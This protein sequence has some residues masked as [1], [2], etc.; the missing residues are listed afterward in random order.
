MR[1][2]SGLLHTCPEGWLSQCSQ[3]RKGS[4]WSGWDDHKEASGVDLLPLSPWRTRSVWVSQDTAA[5][6]GSSEGADT[7]RGEWCVAP[8]A[9]PLSPA[10]PSHPALPPV[11]RPGP[12]RMTAGFHALPCAVEVIPVP[13]AATVEKALASPGLGVVE[14]PYLLAL[15]GTY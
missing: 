6:P 2:G 7:V 8:W 13:F 15:A 10:L 4:M 9:P 12:C 11:L 3:L 5:S 1:G 14:V